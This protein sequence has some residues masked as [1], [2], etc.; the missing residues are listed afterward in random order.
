[1]TRPNRPPTVQ[2]P[3]PAGTG[4]A[5]G[6]IQQARPTADAQMPSR[7]T[8]PIVPEP[9]PQ[10][11]P[12]S[13]DDDAAIEAAAAAQNLSLTGAAG[14]QRGQAPEALGVA[15]RENISSEVASVNAAGVAPGSGN[16]ADETAAPA[17]PMGAVPPSD[18]R[19]EGF[20][21]SGEGRRHRTLQFAGNAV[22]AGEPSRRYVG[23]H[24]GT[25]R[26]GGT[27]HFPRA[28][29]TAERAG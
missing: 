27:F 20:G 26:R 22:L 2:Q 29:G 21:S 16:A 8:A 10:A 14:T 11:G 5:Q 4:A 3:I 12:I 24:E 15:S 28:R 19:T 7:P 6:G 13:I 18:R 9:A 25:L 1:M 23:D 17:A